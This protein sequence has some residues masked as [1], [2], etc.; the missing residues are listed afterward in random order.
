MSQPTIGFNSVFSALGVEFD[1]AE[2]VVGVGQGQGGNADFG[3]VGDDGVVALQTGDTLLDGILG[4]EAEMGE[5]GR[6]HGG[7]NFS[8]FWILRRFVDALFL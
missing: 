7:G 1:G 8:A 6:R 2:H 3:G 5:F 4:A